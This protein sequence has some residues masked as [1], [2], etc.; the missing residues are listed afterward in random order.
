MTFTFDTSEAVEYFTKM[1]F[2]MVAYEP[3]FEKLKIK[4]R[5]GNAFNF[6]VQGSLYGGWTPLA[7]YTVQ[8]RIK[9]GFGGPAPILVRDGSLMDSLT[10]LDGPPNVIGPESATFGTDISYAKF[11][12]YGTHRMPK[13]EIMPDPMALAPFAARLV[14]NQIVP[15]SGIVV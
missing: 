5:T 14:L 11:H 2:R 6:A 4:V 9:H 7:P 8:D 10:T 13:R 3:V 1:A 15:D 12:Q